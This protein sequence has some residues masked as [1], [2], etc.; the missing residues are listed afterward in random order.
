MAQL[1]ARADA[2]SATPEVSEDAFL[3]GQLMLLQPVRGYRAGMDAVLLAAAAICKSG[4][5]RVLDL[6]AGVGTV[7]LCIA[8]RMPLSN[9]TLLERQQVLVG[10]ATQNIARNG[11]G[12][13]ARVVCGDVTGP[14]AELAAA[15]IAEGGFELVVANPPYF[16]AG[17]GTRSP[18]P[19][20][21]T[22]HEMEAA[23]DSAGGGGLERWARTMARAVR[24]GGGM[25]LIHT[26]E[27]LPAIYAA[28]G[29]RFGGLI[30]R[31]VH[32]KAGE[33][34][35]R[36]LVSGV[37]GSRAKARLLDR[38]VLHGADGS[39]TRE[40]EAVLRHGEALAMGAAI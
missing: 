17:A 2:A 38:L 12:E 31:P 5:C 29:G 18:E 33:P 11:L 14:A 40:A 22:S 9:V 7:G 6:G 16:D 30:V 13:R 28:M 32:P 27:A 4:N 36:V 37:K 3:G 39:F 19:I 34:A 25:V 10:L 8:R 21:A 23:Q 24:P 35:H 1:D 26:A 15:G 20:K